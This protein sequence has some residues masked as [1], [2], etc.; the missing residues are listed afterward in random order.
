[1]SFLFG[2]LHEKRVVA[3]AKLAWNI[4]PVQ[5]QDEVPSFRLLFLGFA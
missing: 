3:A 2:G 4:C 1:M 5:L